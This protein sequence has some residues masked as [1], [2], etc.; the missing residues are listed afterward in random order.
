MTS[1]CPLLM[2]LGFAVVGVVVIVTGGT[3]VEV[4]VDEGAGD[5]G[6]IDK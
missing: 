4:V 2:R 1:L 3:G 5:L 6:L